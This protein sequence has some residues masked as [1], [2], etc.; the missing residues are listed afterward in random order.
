MEITDAQRFD[1]MI[2]HRISVA[3]HDQVGWHAFQNDGVSA[4][5]VF[6]GDDP[7][8]ALDAYLTATGQ[9]REE[10]RRP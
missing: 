2:R 5:S 9:P 3:W 10:P 7:C 6:R 4:T 1:L 8:S